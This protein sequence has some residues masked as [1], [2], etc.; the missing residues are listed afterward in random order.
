MSGNGHNVEIWRSVPTFNSVCAAADG[1][2]KTFLEEYRTDISPSM[3]YN[4]VTLD[5]GIDPQNG[6][7]GIEAVRTV[8]AVS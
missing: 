5:G 4:L 3:T 1:N 6:S 7:A 8:F 2:G